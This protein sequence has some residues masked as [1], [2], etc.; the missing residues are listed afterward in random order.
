MK[1]ACFTPLPL[2]VSRCSLSHCCPSRYWLHFLVLF[3]SPLL[4][5]HS[6]RF[7]N[8]DYA[9]SKSG[10]KPYLLS[11]AVST[12]IFFAVFTA[13]HTLCPWYCRLLLFQ[14]YYC[15]FATLH[16]FQ[17]PL[18]SPCLAPL[19]CHLRRSQSY[20]HP[21][22]PTRLLPALSSL[23]PFMS[24]LS[25]SCCLLLLVSLSPLCCIVP[26]SLS[27]LPRQLLLHRSTFHLILPLLSYVLLPSVAVVSSHG[28][29]YPDQHSICTLQNLILSLRIELPDAASRVSLS[30]G[31]FSFLYLAATPKPPPRASSLRTF[32]P[33]SLLP[34]PFRFCLS[35]QP[36][37]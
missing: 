7:S 15:T 11:S 33:L 2:I 13:L 4:S 34:S 31:Y 30:P 28:S 17:F 37:P 23:L 20:S 32:V 35:R 16:H 36:H 5:R 27:L 8:D 19:P 3:C 10:F 25:V 18:F 21:S 12:S 1:T 6:H 9:T 29:R 22:P 14:C 26:V 24:S